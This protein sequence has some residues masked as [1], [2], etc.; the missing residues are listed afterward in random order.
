M[1]SAA[2]D[3]VWAQA[4]GSKLV[5]VTPNDTTE[6]EVCRALYVGGSGTVVLT[7]E[8]DTASVT[9]AGVGAGT[10]LP[11]RAKLVKSTGTTATSIVAI[12]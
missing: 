9:L 4:P 8:D 2:R 3:T 12:Y 7:A 5:A 11:V 6:F 1:T 10:I